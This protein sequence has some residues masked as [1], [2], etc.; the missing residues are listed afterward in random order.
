MKYYVT[1]QPVDASAPL[2]IA[3][4][5]RAI[6]CDAI[7]RHRRMCGFDLAYLIATDR[8]QIGRSGAPPSEPTP[9]ARSDGAQYREAMA[10]RAH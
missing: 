1:A 2:G 10:A 8:T 5:Y 4:I 7:A 9:S 3:A 6:L